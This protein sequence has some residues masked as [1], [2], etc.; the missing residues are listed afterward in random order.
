MKLTQKLEL[1]KYLLCLIGILLVVNIITAKTL[2]PLQTSPRIRDVKW[3]DIN[4]WRVPF[5]N[6]GR[7]G[8]QTSSTG[9][10]AG[11]YWPFPYRNFYIF[12]AG[13]WVG[14]ILGADTFVTVGYNPNTGQG[15]FFPTPAAY[16]EEG[17]GN[18]LDRI[19]KYPTDWPPPQSRFGYDTTLVPQRSF[20]LQDMWCVYCDLHP[21]YHTA[22]GRPL[23]IEVYQTIYA[24]NYP[25]NQDI[26]F[27]IYKVKNVNA[28]DTIKNTYLGACM[29]PD[30]GSA[31]DDM[32]G[33]ILNKFIG[34]DTIRNVGFAGDNDNAEATGT[35]WQT[36]VPG[37]VAYKFLE[38][39]RRPDGTLLG[40]TSFKKFTIDID[41]ARDG[42]QYLTMAG[43]DY[44][45]LVY[46]PYDSIDESPADKRFIQCT[47]PFDLPP[48]GVATIIVAAIAA[49]YGDAN[50]PWA[51]RDTTDLKQLCKAAAAAQ[52]IYDQGWILP[53]PPLAPNVTLIPGDNQIRI[54]WDDIA[55]KTPDPY[56]AIA[57]NPSSPGYDPAYLEFDLEGYKVFKSTDGVNW[58]L[59][60]Q[61]D[62]MNGIVFEDTTQAESIR[63]KAT[64]AGVFYSYLDKKVVNG[65]TY[66]YRVASY[67]RN[68]M[69]DRTTNIVYPLT[70][71]SNP[72]P[73]TEK[74]CWEAPNYDTFGV[75]LIKV[76]GDTVKSGLKCSTRIVNPF[77]ITADTLTITF[78]GPK[79]VGAANKALHQFVVTKGN[80][81]ILDTVSTIYTINT[82]LKR[83]F[84]PFGGTE[85]IATTTISN[86]SK[87]FDTVYPLTGNYSAERL[88][89]S[90]VVPWQYAL[91]AFRGSDYKIVWH[92][93]GTN[94]TCEVFD[95]TNGGILV[96]PTKFR[97]AVGNDTFA[98][99]W[100]FTSAYTV[101][102]DTILTSTTKYMY[103]NCGY[104]MLNRN[105]AIGSLIDSIADGD[106]W[107]V[108]GTK[109]YGTAPYYNVYQ[110]IGDPKQAITDRKIALN[111]KVV[112]N[113]YIVTNTWEVSK[114]DRR[115]AFT[116][117][118]NKCTIRI[119]TM[120]GNLV[121]VIE[122]NS[123]DGT[124]YWNLL[125]EHD[126]LIAAGV[127]I[128]HIESSVGEQIGKFAIIH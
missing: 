58:Q 16:W 21:D 39:P 77:A 94:R 5:Y 29:D 88:A 81:L 65:F 53:S 96:P 47:G 90:T 80:E 40:L 122:H 57:S 55:E 37:V 8:I 66:Y 62:L 68:Y 63:T 79:Y 20:S 105:Q 78:S 83:N 51:Q 45:T 43:Y 76:I 87:V 19:Y 41:P 24:W 107:F 25:S 4:R 113:P 33:L 84:P 125:N 91:W 34:G 110:L 67:D 50:E 9:D 89:V 59:L 17:T 48:G 35:T 115:I 108:K 44:R 60:T 72:T 86:P 119:F 82:T 2:F 15:E 99:G 27:I 1:K 61:C 11:G 23:G 52:F 117:L 120:A 97:S 114:Y 54:V 103:I 116:R 46:S 85:I 73:V 104:I 3:L 71:E 95:M 93:C 31:S 109:I 49:P 102:C 18:A 98:N 69:T 100:G 36:G 56:Y 127:Y 6:E 112:P 14:A 42:E 118:P 124:E 123:T 64:D 30:I 26:F 70:L 12:G 22:P 74:P 28:T 101:Q 128:F 92:V 13:P 38:G 111:V 7:Y 75:K 106:E 32:V 121:K 10:I 126:Q